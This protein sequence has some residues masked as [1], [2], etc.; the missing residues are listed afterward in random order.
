M[1]STGLGRGASCLGSPRR[2]RSEV[3]AYGAAIDQGRLDRGLL[4]ST[5]SDDVAQSGSHADAS[6]V[7][8]T[9]LDGNFQA[10]VAIDHCSVLPIA[11]VNAAVVLVQDEASQRSAGPARLCRKVL[12]WEERHIGEHATID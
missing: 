6:C 8:R 11:V 7:G 4:L 12:A 9:G 1:S 3:S 5:G 10:A 2:T